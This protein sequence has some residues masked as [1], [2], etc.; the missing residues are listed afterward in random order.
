MTV[1]FVDPTSQKALYALDSL[2]GVEYAEPFRSVPSRLRFQHRS[3]RTSIQGISPKNSLRRLLN[4]QLEPV[5]LPP[6]GVV[7]TD[8]LAM[9][10][11]IRP[12]DLLTVEVLE[13]SARSGR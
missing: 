7:L 10:L 4:R 5:E 3:Y 1:T 2:P 11:G 9:I 12:G 8:Y 6:D 13:G